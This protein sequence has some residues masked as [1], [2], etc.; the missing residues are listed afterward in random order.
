MGS[1][2]DDRRTEAKE[3]DQS[4]SR[5]TMRDYRQISHGTV[6][7]NQ[8]KGN[9]LTFVGQA[10]VVLSLYFSKKFTRCCF[11]VQKATNGILTRIIGVDVL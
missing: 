4:L 10:I 3:Y 7:D 9:V 1:P 6:G 2:C 11:V 5:A 8:V